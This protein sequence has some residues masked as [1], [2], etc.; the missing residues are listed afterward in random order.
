M[1]SLSLVLALTAVGGVA[2]AQPGP[3]PQPPPPPMDTTTTTT[4][5]TDPGSPDP[6]GQPVAQQQ[7]TPVQTGQEPAGD[8][9]RPAG[10]AIGLGIGFASPMALDM[11][12]IS[13]LRLRLASGLTFEPAIR[14]SNTSSSMQPATGSDSTDK[15]SSFGVAVLLRLP[16]VSHGKFDL[17]GLGSLGFSTTKSNP[18]GDYNATTNNNFDLGY[19]VAVSNW[20]S[21]HWNLSFSITNPLVDYRQTKVQPGVPNMTNKSSDTTLG[22]IFTPEVFMMIHMYN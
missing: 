6:Q 19:G 9:S 22:I 16:L 14:I 4:T 11:P 10:L 15:I 1:R 20:L 2:S 17:E 12:N 7:S 5:T 18:D 8:D 3:P 13:T 21:P